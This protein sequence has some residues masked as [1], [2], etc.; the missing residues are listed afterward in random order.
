MSEKLYWWAFA[1]LPWNNEATFTISQS[2]ISGSTKN[3][4]NLVTSTKTTLSLWEENPSQVL[5]QNIS[6][7]VNDLLALKQW[8]WRIHITCWTPEDMV[9]QPVINKLDPSTSLL[10]IN[11]THHPMILQ[12]LIRDFFKK[13]IPEWTNIEVE[14]RSYVPESCMQDM[15]KEVKPKQSSSEWEWKRIFEAI[16]AEIRKVIRWK[17]WIS[18]DL[19]RGIELL[20]KLHADN[21]K[22]LPEWGWSLF[23]SRFIGIPRERNHMNMVLIAPELRKIFSRVFFQEL[24]ADYNIC[25]KAYWEKPN[26]PFSDVAMTY[27]A[28]SIDKREASSPTLVSMGNWECERLLESIEDFYRI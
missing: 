16:S 3:N 10:E 4:I 9:S 17:K 5:E 7:L 2:I 1:L 15:L 28:D 21:Q 26:P 12:M 27:I 11:E 23:A 6:R 22:V 25:M 8:D 13:I 24:W 14:P 19:R 20:A 18:D